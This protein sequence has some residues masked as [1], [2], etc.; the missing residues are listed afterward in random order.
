MILFITLLYKCASKGQCI[1]I[2]LLGNKHVVEYLYEDVSQRFLIH[3]QLHK[4]KNGVDQKHIDFGGCM[5]VQK[6]T[7]I[8]L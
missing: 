6:V 5:C 3:F 8:S 7:E 1:K 4:E 2:L